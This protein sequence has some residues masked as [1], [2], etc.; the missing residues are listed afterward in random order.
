MKAYLAVLKDSFR[1][2]FASRVLWILLG[3]TTLVLAAVA[4]IG[5]SEKPA[6]LLRQ[7]S[8]LNLLAL[9]SKIEMQGRADTPSPGKQI[10]SR[11]GD[12]LKTKLS[13]ANGEEA[14]NSSISLGSDVLDGLNKLMP[15]RTFYDEQARSGIEL[16]TE[17]T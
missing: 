12:N 5:L 15:D 13:T 11:W 14:G 10:W 6:T 8:I 7:N 17:T 16:N 2:A 1:E 4:P 9:I 3:L